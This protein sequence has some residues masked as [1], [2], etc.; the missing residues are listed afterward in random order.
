MNMFMTAKCYL[1]LVEGIIKSKDVKVNKVLADSVYYRNDIF[2][3]L[4]YNRII[5]PCIKLR[6]NA[7]VK[8]TTNHVLK[9]SISHIS[10]IDLQRWRKDGIV[11][12]GKR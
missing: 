9:K 4:S 10:K 1:R 7:K 6:K 12:Y 8:F 11:S 5:V 3:C 2:N